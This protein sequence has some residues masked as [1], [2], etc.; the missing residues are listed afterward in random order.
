M[1]QES[2]ESLK[3]F[4]FESQDEVLRV[5]LDPGNK[6]EFVRIMFSDILGRPMD[7]S[8]PVSELGGAFREGKGFDGSSVEGF[9]RIEESHLVIAG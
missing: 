6:I 7:F 9:V 1:R 3:R 5:I 2:S 8:I 4:G